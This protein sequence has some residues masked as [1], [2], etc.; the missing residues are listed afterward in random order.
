MR[1]DAR[2]RTVLRR[3]ARMPFLD[4]LELASV[5]GLPERTVYSAVDRL[6]DAGLVAAV[7]H[8]IDILRSTRRFHLTRAGVERLAQAEWQPV[9]E[10]LRH[11]PLS[12]QWQRALL[13]RLDAAAGLYRL[14]AR[15]GAEV[16]GV[17]FVWYRSLRLDAALELPGGRTVGVLRIGRTADRTAAAKRVHTLLQEPLP[18]ALLV[19]V[20][21]PIRLRHTRRLFAGARVPVF[22]AVEAD[23]V[24]RGAAARIWQPPTIDAD[25]SLRFVLEEAPTGGIVPAEPFHARARMPDDLA[26]TNKGRATPQHHL[27]ALLTPAQK[28]VL[29]LVADWPW[30]TVPQAAG[31]LGMAE[32]LAT[33]LVRALE[34]FGLVASFAP[35]GKRRLAVTDGGLALLAKRDRTSAALAKE[36]FSVSLRAPGAPLSWRNLVG[37]RTRQLLRNLEHTD[38]VHGFLAGLLTQMR[39]KGWEVI[40]VDPPHRSSRYFRYGGRRHAIHPDAFGLLR[41]GSL[42]RPFFL[43]LERR[44]VRP[45]T[46]EARLAPYLRYYSTYQPND[47]HRAQP[48]LMV[49]YDDEVA[50]THLRHKADL[51]EMKS[52]PQLPLKVVSWREFQN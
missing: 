45:V 22:L 11:R 24:T 44:A 47:D 31:M 26:V 1:L 12:A 32:G 50:A 41:G 10:L 34:G 51:G 37:R 8:A 27:P 40:Q 7:R 20:P 4:R 52:W 38:G 33:K 48:V 49:A 28:R 19:L 39:A 46:M 13:E 23:A 43:E 14:A 21:D 35:D 3:L 17:G 5:E 16:G 15:I 6:L 30:I 29:D 36:R 18:G 2:E 9:D 42:L 25:L